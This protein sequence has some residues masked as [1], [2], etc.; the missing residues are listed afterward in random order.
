MIFTI[1]RYLRWEFDSADHFSV[2]F[3]RLSL[4]FDPFSPTVPTMVTTDIGIWSETIG[5]LVRIGW[6][7]RH[8]D[9][10]WSPESSQLNWSD[11]TVDTDGNLGTKKMDWL[12]N[13][14]SSVILNDRKLAQLIGN[15]QKLETAATSKIF[16]RQIPQYFSARKVHNR[17]VPLCS[18]SLTESAKSNQLKP[19]NYLVYILKTMAN[20]D[21]VNHP[22]L[23][24]QFLP[25]SKTLS[26]DCYKTSW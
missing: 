13:S 14:N 3:L 6:L 4:N 16:S 15:R 2:C 18:P 10:H 5:T 20:T 24:D 17:T 11:T 21:L 9:W 1:I 19:Y 7:C 12:E 22:E 25:W 26:P 8:I 23:I